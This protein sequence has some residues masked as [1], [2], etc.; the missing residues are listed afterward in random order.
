MEELGE[1]FFHNAAHFERKLQEVLRGRNRIALAAFIVV[2]GVFAQ[3]TEEFAEQTRV[4]ALYLIIE[5]EL[6]VHGVAIPKV[7][8]VPACVG[9]IQIGNILE[10]TAIEAGRGFTIEVN[11]CLREEVVG[12]FSTTNHVD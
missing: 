2:Q 11:H 3:F 4:E 1:V 6:K 7:V 8:I 9:C 5:V 12:D 10:F